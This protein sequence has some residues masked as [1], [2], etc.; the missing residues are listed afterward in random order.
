MSIKCRARTLLNV[1]PDFLIKQNKKEHDPAQSK[2]VLY[3][4]IYIFCTPSYLELSPLTSEEN[5]GTSPSV[6][7]SK[8]NFTSQFYRDNNPN[9]YK[10]GRYVF[11]FIS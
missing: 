7:W 6:S 2:N 9:Q 1:D 8:F 5:S 10:T 11:N 3:M 4:Y